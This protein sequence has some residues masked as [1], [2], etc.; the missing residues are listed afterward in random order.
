MIGGQNVWKRSF[1]EVQYRRKDLLFAVSVQGLAL[2]IYFLPT[3]SS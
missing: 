2:T 3:T 1:P